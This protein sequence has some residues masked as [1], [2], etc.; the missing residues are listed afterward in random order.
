MV[1][2]TA[3]RDYAK[4]QALA[5][6]GAAAPE[7][8]SVTCNECTGVEITHLPILVSA[9]SIARANHRDHSSTTRK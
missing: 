8:F 3:L 2:S 4:G 1:S 9:R 7:A 5:F 6:G